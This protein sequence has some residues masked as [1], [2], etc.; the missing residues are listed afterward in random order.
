MSRTNR[1]T[2]LKAAG[3]AT[4]AA[5]VGT[6]PGVAEAASEP[7]RE[8]VKEPSRLPQEPLVA[9]VRDARKSEVTIV[10]GLH[11]ATYRDRAL[12]KRLL[13]VARSHGGVA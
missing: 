7:S 9:I 3:V 12:V 6:V 11:R 5:I 8:L 1:R 10:S 4:G 2:F 13:D